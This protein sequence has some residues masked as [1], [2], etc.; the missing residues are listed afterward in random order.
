MITG[1]KIEIISA[2]KAWTTF[3]YISFDTIC[4]SQTEH[5]EEMYQKES[6]EVI[7]PEKLLIKKD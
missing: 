1:T 3:R 6:I 2:Q 7:N 4:K 5:V